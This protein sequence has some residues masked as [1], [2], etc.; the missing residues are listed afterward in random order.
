MIPTNPYLCEKNLARKSR[1]VGGAASKR[2]RVLEWQAAGETA[3]L[4]EEGHSGVPG[5]QPHETVEVQI[6][7]AH[8]VIKRQ[9][10]ELDVVNNVTVISMQRRQDDLLGEVAHLRRQLL[11]EQKR[12]GG[13]RRMRQSSEV[14]WVT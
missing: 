3:G 13:W 14:R 5:L 9:K 2:S 4:A 1:D 10:E 11:E 7:R 6:V 12:E 8:E